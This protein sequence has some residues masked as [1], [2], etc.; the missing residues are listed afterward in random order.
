MKT[1]LLKLQPFLH[2]GADLVLVALVA[3]LLLHW[4]P[5]SKASDDFVDI[6]RPNA[7]RLVPPNVK[8][9]DLVRGSSAPVYLIDNELHKRWIVSPEVF[10]HCARRW[11]WRWEDIYTLPDSALQQVPLGPDIVSC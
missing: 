10:E 2:L 11:G 5:T 7:P 9:G 6:S 1:R 4:W 8:P 3:F